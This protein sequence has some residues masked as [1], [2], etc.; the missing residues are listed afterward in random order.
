MTVC[1]MLA[2]LNFRR[3]KVGL[4]CN[5]AFIDTLHSFLI[6]KVTPIFESS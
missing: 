2:L 5:D 4:F 6:E 1:W 3:R